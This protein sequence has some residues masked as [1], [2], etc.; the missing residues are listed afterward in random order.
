MSRNRIPGKIVILTLALVA[1]SG[2]DRRIPENVKASAATTN[3]AIQHTFETGL[4]SLVAALDNFDRIV[5]RGDVAS[6]RAAFRHARRAY[7][8]QETLISED[9]PSVSGLLN[10]PLPEDDDNLEAP[11]L[12]QPAAFQRIESRIFD[13]DSLSDKERTEIHAD[14]AIMR[15]SLVALRALTPYLGLTEAHLL[16][17]MRTELARITILGFAGFDS[18][19]SGDAIVEASHAISGMAMLA[20]SAAGTFQNRTLWRALHDTL[21]LSQQNLQRDSSALNTDRLRFISE[22]AAAIGRG[23]NRLRNVAKAV[24][25]TLR[26]VWRASSATVYE[27]DAFDVTAYAPLF[28]MQPSAELIALGERLFNDT[29]LSG[30]GSRA[31]STCHV[32]AL[33]FTDG[34]PRNR[35]IGVNGRALSR[36]TPTLLN[37]ALQPNFFADGSATTLED[38]IRIVLASPLEMASSADDAAKRISAD[39]GYR[40][41]F[42]RL[43]TGTGSGNITEAALRS[44]LATYVRSLVKMN[45]RFDAAVQGDANAI[46]VSERRGFNV[47]MGKARCGTCHFA[48]LFSGVTPPAYLV[49]DP[50][51]IGVPTRADTVRATIDPDIGRA[52]IDSMKTHRFA[53]NVP[54]LRNI[55]RTA[56]YM[57]NGAYATLEQVVDFYNRGGGVGIGATVPGQTLSSAPLQLTADEQRDLIAFLKSLTDRAFEK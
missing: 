31:C 51:I 46:S 23:I 10:G 44:V 4:D 42:A 54:T 40:N 9:G 2:C 7:K 13:N 1:A 50:E 16:N 45:S 33:A 6:L 41:A 20:E 34:Q 21:R 22:D 37:V 43:M 35:A 11:P 25:T 14:I 17:A 19:Q 26:A 3:A 24:D 5:P 48:P 30:P 29:R 28:A 12:G 49:T 18:D 55:A 53:F 27:R 39:S 52:G 8:L 38:Q 32:Q 47:Y 36:N 57:H 56:P 15:Q